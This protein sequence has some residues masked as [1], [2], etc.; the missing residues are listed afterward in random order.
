MKTEKI[1]FENASGA[2]LSALL[3]RPEDREPSAFAIFAH[4]FTCSKNLKIAASLARR[5]TQEGIALL[6]FDFTGLGQSEGEFADTSFTT[7]REDLK[8]ACR[9]LSENASGPSLLIG[10]SLGG[11]AV[12]SVAGELDTV[13]AVA[14]V[15]APADVSHVRHLFTS[16]DFD[17]SGRADVSIGGR[18]FTISRDFV[19]DL[20]RHNLEDRL[21]S[22]RKPLLIF[23]SPIDNIVG[24]ENAEKIY[25]AA[26]H[27]KSFISLDRADHLV[28]EERDARFLGRVLA[29]WARYYIETAD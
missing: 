27:P 20:E 12:L 8:S 21:A 24:V 26:R 11:A 10:H 19:E 7:N 15:G 17:E 4:C 22:M 5:I 9:W 1:R 13:R 16:A 28:S 6:R 29:A 18:P 14:T 2:S 25:R 3:D 23:H